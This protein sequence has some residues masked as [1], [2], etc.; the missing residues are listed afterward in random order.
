M[1]DELVRVQNGQDLV[2][3]I[4]GIVCEHPGDPD[5]LLSGSFIPTNPES[6]YTFLL[7]VNRGGVLSTDSYGAWLAADLCTEEI[8]ACLGVEGDYPDLPDLYTVWGFLSQPMQRRLILVGP[9]YTVDIVK[10]F[11]FEEGTAYVLLDDVNEQVME[12]CTDEGI[13]VLAMDEIMTQAA[14]S[15]L[16]QAYMGEP[17]ANS[18]NSK[19]PEFL[20]K[21]GA[22]VNLRKNSG[23]PVQAE[24]LIDRIRSSTPIMPGFFGAQ[25]VKVDYDSFSDPERIVAEYQRAVKIFAGSTPLDGSEKMIAPF[26]PEISQN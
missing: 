22:Q 13:D 26:P 5:I 19:W 9:L 17:M 6:G 10:P 7:T 11:G 24:K 2:A 1:G 21:L 14:M 18:Y 12:I 15:L 23:I 25:P 4:Q 3:I 16:Y 8:E 20:S